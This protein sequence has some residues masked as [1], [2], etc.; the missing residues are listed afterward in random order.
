MMKILKINTIRS[1]LTQTDKLKQIFQV[2][3]IAF[4]ISSSANTSMP[5]LVISLVCTEASIQRILGF[6]IF[7]SFLERHSLDCWAVATSYSKTHVSSQVMKNMMNVRTSATL[8]SI[9]FA[10][11]TRHRFCKKFRYFG[12]SVALTCFIHKTLTKMS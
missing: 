10:N 4:K 8:S 9:S 7:G 2:F 6:F 12:T 1:N 5:K 11:F 3:I